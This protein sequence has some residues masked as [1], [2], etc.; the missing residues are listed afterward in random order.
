MLRGHRYQRVVHN[1]HRQ[2]RDRKSKDILVS[3]ELGRRMK[4]DARMT[5]WTFHPIQSERGETY[6][7]QAIKFI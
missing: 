1:C 5:G 4:F 3:A 7:G 6:N 2:A